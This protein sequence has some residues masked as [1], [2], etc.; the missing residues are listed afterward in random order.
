MDRLSQVKTVDD[1]LQVSG[2]DSVWLCDF[3]STLFRLW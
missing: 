3:M 1:R 2:W